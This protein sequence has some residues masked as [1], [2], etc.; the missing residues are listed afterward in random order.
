MADRVVRAIRER[1]FY[2]LAEDDWRRAAELRCE[3]VRLGRNPTF[4]PPRS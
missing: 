2:V 3:D 1:R 4:A